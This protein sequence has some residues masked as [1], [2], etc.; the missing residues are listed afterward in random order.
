MKSVLKQ[1]N[2]DA[3]VRTNRKQYFF[4]DGMHQTIQIMLN[5]R[6]LST[7]NLILLTGSDFVFSL[8]ANMFEVLPRYV[9]V[10]VLQNRSRLGVC[11][12]HEKILRVGTER[13][14]LSI[15]LNAPQKQ[16]HH[17]HMASA[18][19]ERKRENRMNRNNL[20]GQIEFHF[21]NDEYTNF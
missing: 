10:W 9:C 11:D 4:D 12:E 14:I 21:S 3:Q 2:F 1:T 5:H 8:Q 13:K 6:N 16:Q 7:K 19:F 18:T 15:C 17:L 20:I